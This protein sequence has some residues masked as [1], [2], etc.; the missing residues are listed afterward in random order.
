MQVQ[1]RKAMTACFFNLLK[2]MKEGEKRE[3][4]KGKYQPVV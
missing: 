1:T 3:A 2:I 4:L